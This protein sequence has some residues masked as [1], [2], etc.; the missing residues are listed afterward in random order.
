MP[1]QRLPGGIRRLCRPLSK[2]APAAP[3]GDG[4]RNGS[5]PAD[6]PGVG[7]RQQEPSMSALT[8]NDAGGRE[9]PL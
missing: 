5:C 9:N 7:L 1:P 4:Q 3:I 8:V 2:D 6:S